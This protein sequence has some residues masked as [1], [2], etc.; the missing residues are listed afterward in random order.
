MKN[1]ILKEIKTILEGIETTL[2]EAEKKSPKRK[3]SLYMEKF[4]T[5]TEL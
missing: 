5:I 1:V 3:I 4:M 2:D